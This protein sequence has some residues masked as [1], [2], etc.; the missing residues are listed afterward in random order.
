MGSNALLIWCYHQKQMHRKDYN[1]SRNK[2]RTSLNNLWA[3]KHLWLNKSLHFTPISHISQE[4]WGRDCT[5]HL[6]HLCYHQISK[7]LDENYL[8]L[9]SHYCLFFPETSPRGAQVETH[10]LKS[11]PNLK[12]YKKEKEKRV[13][14][15]YW[16]ENLYM[17]FNS[18]HRHKVSVQLSSV[19]LFFLKAPF[20]AW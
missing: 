13:G 12:K 2:N 17:F 18:E 5:S 1:K 14:G 15:V 9:V 4:F 11:F 3:F 16:W 8:L 20:I 19:T 6:V 7:A 10:L